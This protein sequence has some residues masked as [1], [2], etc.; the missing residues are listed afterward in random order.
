MKAKLIR[1]IKWLFAGLGA[2]L[3]GVFAAFLIDRPA[4]AGG[5]EDFRH[6]NAPTAA[7]PV[8][9]TIDEPKDGNAVSWRP[10][11]SGS[12]SMPN[13]RVWL[14]VHPLQTAQYW[15]QPRVTVMQ[16]GSWRTQAYIGEEHENVGQRF[17]LMA[18][19]EQSGNLRDGLVLQSWPT[20]EARSDVLLVTRR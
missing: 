6:L 11:V 16:D 18:V 17:E 4:P 14:V 2:T 9:V 19:V 3:V 10:V 8:I 15:V 5:A 7:I 20:G 1:Y 12:V 13:A